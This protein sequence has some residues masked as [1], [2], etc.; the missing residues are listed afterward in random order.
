MRLNTF[1]DN[2]SSISLV[3]TSFVRRNNLQGIRATYDL[4]TV[5]KQ[6]IPQDTF[7]FEIII[8]DTQNNE[9]TIKAF[10]ID[11]ICQETESMNVREISKLFPGLSPDSVKRTM[12]KVE[13]LIGSDHLNLH[14]D[15][16]ENNGSLCLYK[17][18]FGTG[19]L[20]AGKHELVKNHTTFNAFTK[21]VA[22]ATIR[23][24]SVHNRKGID[25]F[26][27]ESFGINVPP[28]CNKCLH[29]KDCKFATQQLTQIEQKERE[30]I[31]NELKLDAINNQW[32][33]SRRT[34]R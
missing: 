32:E 19:K 2:G 25:F 15:K 30:C 8:I 10:Q 31:E 24:V 17:S 27:S 7:L 26:T 23:N 20:L 5:N 21:I 12:N 4:I 33:V 9:H 22:K 29:C 13:L 16:I 18:Q 34:R 1:W 3:T 11:D 6:I 28:K 14:P